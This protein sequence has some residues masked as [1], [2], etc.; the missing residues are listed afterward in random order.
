[1]QSTVRD[2][3]ID[4]GWNWRNLHGK[5][6]QDVIYLLHSYFFD[7]NCVEQDVL[8]WKHTNNGIFTSKFAYLSLL[9]ESGYQASQVWGKIWKC[10]AIPKHETLLWLMYHDHLPTNELRRRRGLTLD[11]TSARCEAAEETT[12]HLFQDCPERE[13]WSQWR[14]ASNRQHTNGR[15]IQE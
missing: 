6:P 5:L 2:N 3:W 8:Y 9:Q 12:L 4:G 14:P 13:L 11:A 10:K 15:T 1:M 7:N